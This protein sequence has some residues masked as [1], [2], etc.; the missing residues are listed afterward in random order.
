MAVLV[1]KHHRKPRS[2]G[3]N[4]DPQNISY[5]DIK[6]HRLWHSLFCNYTP[7]QI[8]DEINKIWLDPAYQI[9]L[10]KVKSKRPRIVNI[11]Q[12]TFCTVCNKPSNGLPC[13]ND[14]CPN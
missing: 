14:K 2:L 9:K 10:E 12:R 3:G 6:K 13:K 5:V 1:S 11:Y 4:N 8:F 7:E